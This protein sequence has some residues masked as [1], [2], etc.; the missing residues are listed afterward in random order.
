[1]KWLS[2]NYSVFE[3]LCVRSVFMVLVVVAAGPSVL[4]ATLASQHK[5]AILV[6]ALCQIAATFCFFLA[7]KGMGLGEVTTLNATAPL[8]VVFASIT[9]FREPSSGFKWIAVSVGL[10]GTAIAAAPTGG[11]ML[12]PTLLGLA[13]GFLWALTVLLTRKDSTQESTSVQLLITAVVFGLVS[14]VFA[15]WKVPASWIDIG[16]MAILGLEVYLAQLFFV[17]A[18]R[19]APASLIAPLEYSTIVWSSLLGLI[20]FHDTPTAHVLAGAVLIMMAGVAVGVGE[21]LVARKLKLQS[22][23]FS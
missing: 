10:I 9:L 17:E 7:A 23:R 16:L 22:S 11:V 4:K 13:S 1:M 2:G 6:R 21:Q 19:R 5:G 15:Q 14:G 12:M 20:F 8:I 18:Y 3:L